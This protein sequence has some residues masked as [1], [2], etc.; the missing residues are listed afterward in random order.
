MLN[1]ADINATTTTSL[2]IALG[3]FYLSN[4]EKG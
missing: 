2:T 4:E 1:E 3:M